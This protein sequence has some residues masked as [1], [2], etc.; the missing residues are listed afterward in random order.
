MRDTIV[1]SGQSNTFGLGLE[2]E[3]DPELNS[4]EYLSKGVTLPNHM[5]RYE[6][7]QQYWRP[8][9]WP[10]LVCDA[11]GYKEY[12]IHDKEN[13][14][15]L[16]ANG[17]ETMWYLLE[18]HQEISDILKRT[19]YVILEIG[20][21]RWWDD[22]LHGIFGNEN[23]PSTPIEIENYINSKNANED[24]IKKAIDW[25]LNHDDNLYMLES[26]KKLLNFTKLYPEI[27]IILVP[28]G[29]YNVTDLVNNEII[30]L[31]KN[32]V[33]D[34]GSN[35]GIHHLLRDEKLLVCDKAKA[36]NGN[37]KYNYPEEHASLEGQK[38]VAELVI[39]HIKKLEK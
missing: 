36:F 15:K 29:G 22:N 31:F 6:R 2:W 14:A 39:N 26:F 27:D 19:K 17:S 23:L 38:R 24:V 12:N 28:W 9:R 3:L 20:Y 7:N 34:I 5:D 16:G 33:L 30:S 35:S 37:Y 11:L 25:L 32:C 21:I 13:G 18:R 1:F 10:R 8:Y 4:E